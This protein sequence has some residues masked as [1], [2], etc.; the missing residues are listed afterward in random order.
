M[1]PGGFI[2]VLAIMLAPHWD[3]DPFCG[4]AIGDD[5]WATSCGACSDLLEW[6]QRKASR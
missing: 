2:R 3:P 5:G 6:L 4:E 1:I